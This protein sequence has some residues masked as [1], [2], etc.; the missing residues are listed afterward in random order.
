LQ[1]VT[2]AETTLQAIIERVRA[3]FMETA[4]VRLSVEELQ[5]LCG[6]DQQTAEMVLEFL[7]DTEFLSRTSTYTRAPRSDTSQSFD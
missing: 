7:V 1:E 4:D 2:L 6:V 3:Q 5:R